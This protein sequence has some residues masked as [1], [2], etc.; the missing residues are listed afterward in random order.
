MTVLNILFC[1]VLLNDADESLDEQNEQSV[2]NTF[3]KMLQKNDGSES[4]LVV[5]A[6]EQNIDEAKKVK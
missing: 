6:F 3:N 1:I 4:P 2:L 5:V